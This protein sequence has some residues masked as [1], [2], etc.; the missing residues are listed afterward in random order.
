MTARPSVALA[1]TLALGLL[2]AA[3]ALADCQSLTEEVKAALGASA[4]DRFDELWARMQAEPTCSGAHREDVG[5]LMARVV[6]TSLPTDAGPERIERA[7][8][9]GR[10]W[11]VM[12]ALGDA[13]YGRESWAEAV[14]AYEEALDDMRDEVANPKPPPEAVER[15]AYQRAVQARA[16]APVFVASRQYRGRKTG[17]A[18]PD[19]RTFTATSVPVPVQFETA[20][21]ALTPQGVAAVQD[22]LAYLNQNPHRVVRIIGHTDPRGAPDYNLALSLERAASVAAYLRQLGYLG[23]IEPVGRGEDERFQPDDPGK[24]TVD[25]LFAFDRRVEYQLVQ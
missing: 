15:Q 14:V 3:P 12:V 8:R 7:A 6:L 11:Q 22:I 13:Y 4:V 16:L 17:L 25:Q 9:Y 20:S 5:R 23:Q 21:A 1:A 10:P 24:Y 19:F 18:S 2:T